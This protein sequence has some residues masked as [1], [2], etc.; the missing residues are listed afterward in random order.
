LEEREGSVVLSG[1]HL[2]CGA[3]QLAKLSK[4]QQSRGLNDA[5]HAAGLEEECCGLLRGTRDAEGEDGLHWFGE[6]G[7]CEYDE[8]PA[9]P[10]SSCAVGEGKV[11]P[12]RG[13]G[14]VNSPLLEFGPEGSPVSYMSLGEGDESLV[15]ATVVDGF[16]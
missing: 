1:L 10:G 11:G 13:P 6:G 2:F 9:N 12:A 8:V 16:G 3:S 4:V 15:Y 14:E 5:I 7:V